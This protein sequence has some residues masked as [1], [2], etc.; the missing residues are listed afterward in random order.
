[1]DEVATTKLSETPMANSSSTCYPLIEFPEGVDLN[2]YYVNVRVGMVMAH[3]CAS[4]LT[5]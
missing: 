4:S 1:M 2:D 3:V 5:F